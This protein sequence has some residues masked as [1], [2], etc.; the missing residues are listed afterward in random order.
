MMRK[1]APLSLAALLL[2]ATASPPALAAT[3]AEKQA[4]TLFLEAM[5]LLA[6]KQYAEACEKLAKS[7]E[8]D[9]GMGT[10][11]RLAECYEKLGRLASAFGTYSAVADAAHGAGKLD[12]EAVARKRASALEPRVAKLTIML[13]PSVAA[14]PGVE[15]SRDGVAVDRALWGQPVPVDPGDH[16]VAVKAPNKKPWEGKVWAESSSRLTVS[17]GALEDVVV[18]EPPPPP[19]SM[20]PTIVL[21]AAG[22]VGVVLGASF[23]GV[24]QA[25][26]GSAHTLHDKIVAAGG[27]CVGGGSGKLASD[28]KAL[29]S[30]TSAGDAFGTASIVAFS[31]GG[32][33]LAGMATWLLLPNPKPAR[34]SG[35]T[36]TPMISPGFAGAAASGDF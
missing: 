36:V 11:F 10:Q 22:G 14:L 33:A 15:V 29:S 21:G 28:C 20:L 6:R 25:K 32:A 8:L 27:N 2:V 16:L 4:Q 30:A 5:K 24:R 13:P 1:A 19:K 26:I 17:V 12:R 3:D 35:L 18:V 34:A 7:Q 9:P 23:V 31:T